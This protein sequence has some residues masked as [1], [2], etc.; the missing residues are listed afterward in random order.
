MGIEEY[1]DHC[2]DEHFRGLIE[3][4]RMTAP[5]KQV[6]GP[7]ALYEASARNVIVRLVNDRGL[8]AFELAS[9]HRPEAFRDVELV[10][11]L[12]RGP[13]DRRP[14]VIRLSLAE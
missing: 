12:F 1:L 10:A 8:T 4:F 11:G 7:G 5:T 14:G 13:D 3:D 6:A 9:V 2:F